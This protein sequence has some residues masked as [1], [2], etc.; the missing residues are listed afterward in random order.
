MRRALRSVAAL[1][2]ALALASAAAAH[3]SPSL[4]DQRTEVTLTG[5]ITTFQFRNPHVFFHLQ[6][7]G[8]PD[9]EGEWEIEAQSPRVMTLFGWSST[10]LARGDRVVVV[11]NPPR[12]RGKK[13]ALGRSV[14]KSDGTTRRISWEREEIRKALRE[15]AESQR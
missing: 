14:Q 6:V 9:L 11:V 2:M 15:E 10:S 5:V 8:G 4:F 7:A 12:E 3:H 13:L 1:M